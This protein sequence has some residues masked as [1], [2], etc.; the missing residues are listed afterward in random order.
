[1]RLRA[2]GAVVVAFAVVATS[3]LA[4]RCATPTA[5]I[6][7]V[8]SDL[9]C[10]DGAQVVLFGAQSLQALESSVPTSSATRCDALSTGSYHRGSVVLVPSQADETVAFAIA[11]R[12][13]GADP[14]SCLTNGADCIV[15]KRQIAFIQHDELTAR[16]DLRAACLGVVC[17]TDQT[18]DQGACVPVDSVP[19][20]DDGGVPGDASGD[21]ATDASDGSASSASLRLA[22]LAGDVTDPVDLCVG[23]SGGGPF[24][25]TF[26]N[27]VPQFAVSERRSF[28]PGDYD[29]RVVDALTPGCGAVLV[30]LKNVSLLAGSAHT[31]VFAGA[32]AGTYPPQLQL[33]VDDLAPATVTVRPLDLSSVPESIEF[34]DAT[35]AGNANLGST[36]VFGA[37]PAE[38]GANGYFP[39]PEGE[40]A[41]TLKITKGLTTA[42]ALD[43]LVMHVGPYSLFAVYDQ[44]QGTTLGVLCDDTAPSDAG[45]ALCSVK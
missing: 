34:D 10:T 39:L 2:P 33:Y 1:M 3:A 8:Y 32:N 22:S 37:W 23:R 4:V 21:I 28:T 30:E 18:C 35:D 13:G 24:A 17:P 41:F 45:L 14:S 36:N 25:P 27:G 15:A 11:T 38:A 29:L 20:D 16:I 31:A 9:D 42:H 43:P 40:H 12:K 19:L 5:I 44:A 26:S 6:V 7:D